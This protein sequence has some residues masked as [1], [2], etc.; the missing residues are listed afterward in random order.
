MSLYKNR[1][2][3]V[4]QVQ[5]QVLYFMECMG[6]TFTFISDIIFYPIPPQPARVYMKCIHIKTWII[7][8]CHWQIYI[9]YIKLTVFFYINN[10]N[11]HWINVYFGGSLKPQTCLTLISFQNHLTVLYIDSSFPHHNYY[12]QRGSGTHPQLG[13]GCKRDIFFLQQEFPAIDQP[14]PEEEECHFVIEQLKIFS[15]YSKNIIH[16]VQL[17]NYF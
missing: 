5:V 4:T 17:H 3:H 10:L 16:K 11:I 13:W 1:T 8:H 15:P 9:M 2:E 7:G 12:I 6:Y 14:Q